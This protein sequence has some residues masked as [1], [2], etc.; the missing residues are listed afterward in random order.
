M[1]SDRFRVEEVHIPTG[2]TPESEAALD[3]MIR[4]SRSLPRLIFTP[5]GYISEGL[6][7]LN[8]RERVPHPDESRYFDATTHTYITVDW[9]EPDAVE[10]AIG[11]N[12]P[13]EDAAK[14]RPKEVSDG[15]K[16][17]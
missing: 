2:P 14:K 11:I 10:K 17:P 15:T 9:T 1:N 13:T 5:W 7:L 16:A 4:E 8:Y 12:P 6:A 3:R